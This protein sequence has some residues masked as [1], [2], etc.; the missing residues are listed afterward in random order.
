MSQTVEDFRARIGARGANAT[1]EGLGSPHWFAVAT[2]RID[3]LK[4]I[5]TENLKGIDDLTLATAGA[6]Y[7]NF[8]TLTLV[9]IVGGLMMLGLS[10]LMAMT[11]VRPIGRNGATGLRRSRLRPGHDLPQG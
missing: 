1:L 2:K 9:C 7:R 3:V 4:A 5:E 11:V 8:L 6:A 10:G